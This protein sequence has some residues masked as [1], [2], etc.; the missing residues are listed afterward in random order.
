MG[1]VKKTFAVVLV[2][3][4]AY[5]PL[6]IRFIKKFLRYYKGEGLPFFFVFTDRDPHQFL[7][8]DESG[9]VSW[10][11]TSHDSWLQATN[12]KFSS[13]LEVPKYI[14]D[15]ISID[16]IYYFDA[17]T[18]IP[19]RDFGD[20]FMYNGEFPLIGGEHFLNAT[21]LSNG[22][23]FDRNPQGR[24]YV[25]FESPYPY[26]YCYGAFFGGSYDCIMQMCRV[27]QGYQK[28][29]RIRGYE[30]PVN[31]ESYINHYFHFAKPNVIPCS[32]FEFLVSDK[33]GI[34][35]TRNTGLDISHLL[36]EMKQLKDAV[37]DIQNGKITNIKSQHGI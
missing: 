1:Q 5:H 29:D 8:D 28:V 9:E 10:I 27:L 22:K 33:G 21:T 20:W 4:N 17:D 26:T 6:A 19:D 11:A 36:T 2:A 7:G 14:N 13:I 23:G 35:E 32:K 25:P 12:S 31:D 3:T 16:D 18:N 37:Y 24:S 34:G 15:F 30:P